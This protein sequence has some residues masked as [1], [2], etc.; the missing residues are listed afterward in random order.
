MSSHH[1]VKEGQEPAL[2]VLEAIPFHLVEPLL[3]W[4]PL[5]I[6]ADNALEVVL[7]WG[8][9]IDAVLQQKHPWPTLEETL[10]YQEPITLIPSN[11]NVI[12]EGLKYLSDAGYAAVN[13]VSTKPDDIIPAVEKAAL[14]IQLGIYSDKEKWSFL[15]T[16]TFEKWIS[17]GVCLKIQNPHDASIQTTGLIRTANYFEVKAAGMVQIECTKPF[18]VGE[19]NWA[20]VG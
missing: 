6:V 15:E 3:E 17:A 2:F 4:V 5:V 20:K 12:F 19:M 8:I 1:F 13:I 18:W 11:E 14:P 9:K 7:T 16:G 10:K